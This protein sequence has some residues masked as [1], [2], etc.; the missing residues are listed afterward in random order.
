M[1]S[2]T[3]SF[4]E[5]ISKPIKSVCAI[6]IP[7]YNL[8]IRFFT[9]NPPMVDDVLVWLMDTACRSRKDFLKTGHTFYRGDPRARRS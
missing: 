7:F 8:I 4:P 5:I 9:D 3:L 6:V 2:N 1:A